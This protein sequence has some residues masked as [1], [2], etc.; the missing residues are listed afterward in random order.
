MIASYQSSNI[1]KILSEVI[2]EINANFH[3]VILLVEYIFLSKFL[4]LYFTQLVW[5][6]TRPFTL[7]LQRSRTI[8]SS[9]MPSFSCPRAISFDVPYFDISSWLREHKPFVYT[10]GFLALSDSVPKWTSYGYKL[11]FLWTMKVWSSHLERQHFSC[12][13]REFIGR[14][15]YRSVHHSDTPNLP[16]HRVTFRRVFWYPYGKNRVGFGNCLGA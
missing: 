4:N 3:K 8:S 6:W 11:S 2:V 7:F 14:I 16:I 10:N 13:Y 1:F 12:V 9:S 5:T 15:L